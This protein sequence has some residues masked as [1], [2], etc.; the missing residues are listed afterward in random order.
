[1]N[2]IHRF[3]L[4]GVSSLLV[5]AAVGSAFGQK[6]K[7]A[8]KKPAMAVGYAKTEAVLKARCVGCHNGPGGR[9]GVNLATYESVVG[10]KWRGQPLVVAKK[11]KDSVLV[12]AVHGS[13]APKMP[14]GGSLSPADIATVEAWISA[15]AKK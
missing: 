10:G 9:A 11:P 1:M 8:P 6:P 14:P 3:A 5:L 12:K 13:G 4:V 15:G 2:P 7:A